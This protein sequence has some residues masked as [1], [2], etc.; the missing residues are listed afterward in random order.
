[1]SHNRLKLSCRTQRRVQNETISRNV[2]VR[3]KIVRQSAVGN[4]ECPFLRNS[5]K[6]NQTMP[7]LEKTQT[8]PSKGEESANASGG[9][10]S[11]FSRVRLCSPFSL[12]CTA[13]SRSAGKKQASLGL[14]GR[15]TFA[16]KSKETPKPIHGMRVKY[17]SSICRK[18]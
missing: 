13:R 18:V 8:G 15:S 1:M 7:T 14:A 11:L 9:K 17:G 16:P 10:S 6:R 12:V 4:M 2:P 3:P 5:Q